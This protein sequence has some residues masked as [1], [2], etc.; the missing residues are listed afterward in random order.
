MKNSLYMSFINPYWK[1]MVLIVWV[2]FLPGHLDAQNRIPDPFPQYAPHE[3]PHITV[4][5]TRQTLNIIVIL[6]D[7]MGYSDLSCNGGPYAT[8]N[9]DKFAREGTRF[10]KYYSAAPICSPS[11]VAL[12]TGME[13]AKWHITT[14]EQDIQ[15]NKN[16]D[17]APYLN[18]IAPSMARTL[19]KKDYATA[20]FG[21][22]HMGGGRDVYFAPPFSA[23]GFDEHSG[24]WESPEPDPLLT[25]TDWIWSPQDS[26]KR[27]ERT[28]Y[29]VD[30]TLDFL[31]RNKGKPCFVNLWS[32]DM[33]TPWVPDKAQQDRFPEGANSEEN[34]VAVLKEFDKQM[35]R[36]FDGLERLGIEDNTIVIFTSDNG[37]LP[38]FEGK[39]SG[40]KRGS[41]L[42]L[43][44]G[45]IAM[46][47]IVRWPNQIAANKVDTVSVLSN[48]DIFPTLASI[49]GSAL[50]TRFS[51]DGLNQERVWLNKPTHREK[52]MYWDYGSHGRESAYNYP[53][54]R[55]RSPNLAIREG[56][57]K[58][59]MN[60][61]GS[62]EQLYNIDVDVEESNNVLDNHK[63]IAA[64]LREMLLIW[65]NN[66]P[67]LKDD[68]YI[69]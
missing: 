2:L 11:R 7:D 3:R 16:A 21:K 34:F 20:H 58:L 30:K 68:R 54:G 29:L 66:L 69:Q 4:N 48:L 60:Y 62:D 1:I 35:G 57:W 52:I 50:P 43:Y 12:L 28:A 9:I 49:T 10:T 17:Q 61:D 19:K 32:D 31:K 63:E 56:S 6:V 18:P 5:T 67:E 33:H 38:T 59:L 8:P 65:R 24:T 46:P 13:P 51:F 22:W 55:N 37:P 45:G 40:F 36:L 47:F 41:K 27:W 39:R 26:V 23:Y 44:E 42:S 15:G 14:F 25:A 64:R 53:K